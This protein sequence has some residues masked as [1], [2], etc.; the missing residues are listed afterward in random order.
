MPCPDEYLI[1]Y[2]WRNMNRAE[3]EDLVAEAFNELPQVFREKLENVA[4]V[5]EEWP[6]RRTL[7]STGIHYPSE[8]LG[9]YHGVPLTER[10][11][12]YGLVAPDKISI[13][14]RPI[15]MQAANPEGIRA[16]VRRVLRHEIAH[17]FGVD[18]DRL[19]QLGA[20]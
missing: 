7:E 16:L 18:D 1:E 12:D 2:N 11:H 13:Y 15:L 10:T 20:Y 9:L 6:D 8:L 19:N 4:I 5:V 3:F 17:Y 14:R